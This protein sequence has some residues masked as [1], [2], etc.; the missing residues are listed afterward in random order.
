[1]KR[2][3]HIVHLPIQLFQGRYITKAVKQYGVTFYL[4]DLEA[5]L[6]GT[7]KQFEEFLDNETAVL[8]LCLID[9]LREAADIGNK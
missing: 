6:V 5:R 4:G 3:K 2:A 8:D 7:D 1:V 9:E